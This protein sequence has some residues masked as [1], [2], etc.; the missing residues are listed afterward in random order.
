LTNERAEVLAILQAAN[1]PMKL[2]EIAD[3]VDKKRNNVHKLIAALIVAGRVSKIG[4]GLY[5][6][7]RGEVENEQKSGESGESSSIAA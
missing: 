7:V 3:A 2:G 1:A 4:Y 6:A 5:E